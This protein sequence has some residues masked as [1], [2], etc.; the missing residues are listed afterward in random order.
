[1]RVAR[2]GL[3]AAIIGG[4]LFAVGGETAT[5]VL[6]TVEVYDIAAQRWRTGT[7][8]SRPRHG[9]TVV[10]ARPRLYAL[11]GAFKPSHTGTTK[12]AESLTVPS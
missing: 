6:A 8:M 12:T 10:T 2:N 5:Q 11:A 7:P 9:M 3:G 4:R 1:M